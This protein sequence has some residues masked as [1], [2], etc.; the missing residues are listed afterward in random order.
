MFTRIV[1]T[2]YKVVTFV[3]YVDDTN[4]AEFYY[5]ATLEENPDFNHYILLYNVGTN[6]YREPRQRWIMIDI[7][8]YN[9]SE[10]RGEAE[11]EIHTLEAY[12]SMHNILMY[13]GD[14]YNASTK[15]KQQ[16]KDDKRYYE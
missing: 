7:T 9:A 15:F 14:T 10:D 11:S 6:L 3:P 5:K 13:I 1:Q 16:L 2:Q 4:I 8:E 12:P